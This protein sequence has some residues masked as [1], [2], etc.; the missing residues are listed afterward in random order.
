M[1]EDTS[2]PWLP[3]AVSD[4]PVDRQKEPWFK[5]WLYT[6][7]REFGTDVIYRPPVLPTAEFLSDVNDSMSP[8]Q[9]E[10]LITH[11]CGLMKVDPSLV[12]VELFDGSAEK[13]RNAKLGGQRTVGH[14]R[15]KDGR[16]IIAL[17]RSEFSDPVILTAIAVHEL[18]HLRLQ[19]EGRI[20]PGA[21][22]GE[23]ATDLLTVYF[24]FGIFTTN[25]AMSF[26]RANRGWTI[27]SRGLLDDRDLNGALR[28]EGYRRLGYLRSQEFGY[29]LACYCWLRREEAVPAWAR[30][31]N[32]GAYVYLEQG[33]TYLKRVSRTGELPPRSA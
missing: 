29:A 2:K 32:P 15:K 27:V 19:G 21:P 28:N 26:A 33:L 17:D 5:A 31:V 25:A 24:G 10:D 14:F 30:C 7:G 12:T 16:A 22:D 6:F 1:T 11:L 9:V 20:G 23:R 3:S 8:G 4:C 13:I 18:C